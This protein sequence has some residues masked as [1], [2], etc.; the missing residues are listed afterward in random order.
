MNNSKEIVC[1]VCPNGC[2][3]NVSFDKNKNI[4][5][6]KNALCKNGEA[7]VKD[8]IQ[9]PK[10]SLT[11]TIRVIGGKLP[12]VSVRSDKPIPKEKIPDALKEIN[13]LELKAPV[14]FHQ[15]IIHDLLGTGADIITT[16]Q[17]LK[18]IEPVI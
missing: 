13:K 2:R 4:T 1:I 9:C 14:E 10:R 12:L 15:I 18:D 5:E 17:V 8:E 11:T 6:I 16:K 7:Y 3:I